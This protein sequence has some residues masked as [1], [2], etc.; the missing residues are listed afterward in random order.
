MPHV[1]KKEA[2]RNLT[3][4]GLLSVAVK[5]QILRGPERFCIELVEGFSC[6]E[7]VQ[8]IICNDKIEAIY[9]ARTGT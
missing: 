9:F 7:K 2:E 1:L 8:V 5:K 3:R 6:G 4:Q